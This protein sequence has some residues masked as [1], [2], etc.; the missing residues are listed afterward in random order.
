MYLIFLAVSFL[1]CLIGAICGIGGGVIIKPVLDATGIMSVSSISFLSGC[2]VLSMSIISVYKNRKKDRKVNVDLKIA[3]LMVIGSA[4]GGVLGKE[5]FKYSYVI[6]RDENKVGAIQSLLLILVTFGT[7]IY[8]INS[9]KIKTHNIKN[10]LACV[11]IG[12]ILGFISSFLGIGGG[13]IN[14]IVL[15]YFFSMEAKDAASNSLYIIMFSQLTSLISTL[16]SDSVPNFNIIFLFLMIF[17]GVTGGI[18]SSEINK[19]ISSKEVNKLFALL[20]IVIIGI[21]VYNLVKFSL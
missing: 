1:A 2:S 4:I 17:G 11:I 6:F 8:V 14:L 19:K 18:V 16:I 12:L 7:L 5:I 9:S 21:N 3:R 20:M 15:A 10:T 13:P